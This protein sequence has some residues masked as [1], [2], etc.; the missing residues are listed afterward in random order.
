MEFCSGA[1]IDISRGVRSEF[2]YDNCIAIPRDEMTSPDAVAI[3]RQWAEESDLTIRALWDR[4]A[5]RDPA[6]VYCRFGEDI[7]TVGRMDAAINRV[8]NALL[9]LGVQPGDRV[10]LM[11]PSH[12]DHIVAIFALAKIGAVRI[13]V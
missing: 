6:H 2:N 12:P 3:E 4:R 10:A 11:L 5:G 9:G 7:W 1:A 13:P 8:A